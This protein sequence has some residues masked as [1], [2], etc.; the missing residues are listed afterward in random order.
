MAK[1][2]LNQMMLL[3]GIGTIVI[4]FL[5]MMNWRR[6]VY[7][8]MVAALF[9]GAIRKWIFPQGSELVYFLKDIILLGAYIKF[10]MF[11]D[12]DIRAYRLKIPTTLIIVVCV[13][14]VVTGALNPNLGSL[15]MAG[16][17]LKIYLW[18]FPLAFMVPMLFRSEEE[19]TKMLFRYTLFAIPI[20][21]LGAAQF[22][23]GPGSWLNVY[24]ESA[25]AQMKTV[26][27]FGSALQQTVRI[28][29]TFSFI[30]GHAT[31]IQ[32]FFVLAL[33]L[34]TGIA[35]KRRLVIMFGVLPLI[36]ANGLMAGSRGAVF[37]MM[38]IGAAV[39]SVSSVSRLG[40][41]KGSFIFLAMGA[42]A[43]ALGIFVFFEKAYTAFETRRATTGD[44]TMGRV[45]Y[46]I[47]SVLAASK[48][49]DIAGFGIG[50]SHPATMAMR[51]ALG[52][53]QPKKSCPLYD[54][55]TGQVLGELGWPGFIMWYALRLMIVFHC[56]D[57]FRR[58]PPSLFKSLAL[59]IFCFQ[60]LLLP[61]SMV[62]NHTANL[63]ACAG[64][65]FC[66]IPRLESLV[67][68]RVGQA[69]GRRSFNAP[70]GR[71]HPA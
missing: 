39:G 46:P 29:G 31:F 50:T 67:N 66:L 22:V 18:Y 42:A 61:S 37:S 5:A 23:A 53:P 8:A 28:T 7:A 10:Y 4:I 43:V 15:L 33:G 64:W 21:L 20:C 56:W 2:T 70:S 44:T 69:V 19:M 71:H 14:L 3:G 12:P 36:V 52:I 60:V 34:L 38:L 63:F 1:L 58:S 47:T 65:G 54:S 35:D 16:Y 41:T 45:M 59:G 62:L 51:S 6:A 68:R 26:A 40:K 57:A 49:V 48:E 17:G 24:A 55:E 9:E 30:S 27:T 32:F 13:T 11:P 25:F